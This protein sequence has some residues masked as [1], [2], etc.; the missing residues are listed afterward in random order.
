[1]YTLNEQY[2]ISCFISKYA[3]N[4]PLNIMNEAAQTA[5]TDKIL[6]KMFV[7]TVGKYNKIDFS[8]ITKSKGNIRRLRFY[9]NL[10]ECINQLI[11]INTV[12]NKLPESI[13]LSTA[14]NNIDNLTRIFENGFKSKNNLAILI[15]NT[16]T[17]SLLEATSYVIASSISFVK[18][19]NELEVSVIPGEKSLLIDSLNKFNASVAD[20][21]IVKFITKSKEVAEESMNESALGDFLMNTGTKVASRVLSGNHQPVSPKVGKIF[22]AGVAIVGISALL[23]IGTRIIPFIREMVYLI[24]KAR[25]KLSETAAIQASFLNS[26]ISVLQSKGFDDKVIARQEKWAKRLESLSKKFA[27]DVDKANRDASNEL[28]TEKIDV[29]DVII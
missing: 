24:Y 29:S 2:D 4:T 10:N 20:G 3:E 15:Y 17:Y 22:A 6:D 18:G 26:N 23:Y 16:V 13:I 14:L 28:K 9:D 21:T 11:D 25:H 19:D 1:M 27:L 12:N 7:L 5:L 8:E